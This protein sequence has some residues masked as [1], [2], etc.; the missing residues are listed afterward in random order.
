[1]K[2]PL[3]GWLCIAGFTGSLVAAITNVGWYYQAGN[4]GGAVA[5]AVVAGAVSASMVFVA[6]LVVEEQ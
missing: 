2:G 3:A 6:F 4:Y 5:W 1:M